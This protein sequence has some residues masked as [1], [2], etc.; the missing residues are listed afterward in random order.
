VH[1]SNAEVLLPRDAGLWAQIRNGLSVSLR[2]LT[3]SASWLIVGL[4]FVL[5]WLLLIWGAI[6]L[7]RR[8]WRGSTTTVQ[9]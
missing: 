9:S 6:W 1:L 4:L 7:V 3:L 8:M 2:G 5:P